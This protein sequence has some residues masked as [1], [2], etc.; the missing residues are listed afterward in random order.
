MKKTKLLSYA[1]LMFCL[2][3]TAEASNLRTIVR[4]AGD[5]IALYIGSFGAIGMGLASI[6]MMFNV[7]NANVWLKNIFAGTAIGV[8]GSPIATA[9]IQAFR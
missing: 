8:M 9:I 4:N 3:S 2:I 5:N 1:I 7:P 6:A